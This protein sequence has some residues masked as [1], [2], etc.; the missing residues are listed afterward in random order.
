MPYQTIDEVAEQ[1]R[2]PKSTLYEWRKRGRGPKAFK[3]GRSLLY[4][5]EDVEAWVAA[6]LAAE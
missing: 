3:A 6:Q 4:R 2:K 1:L 5:S